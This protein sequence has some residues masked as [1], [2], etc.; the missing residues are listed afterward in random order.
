MLKNKEYIRFSLQF[1]LVSAKLV[2]DHIIFLE[3][4]T[5]DHALL[6]QEEK[7]RYTNILHLLLDLANGKVES[8]FIE[9][10]DLV[11]KYT[12]DLEEKTRRLFKVEIDKEITKKSLELKSGDFSSTNELILIVNNINKT[13]IRLFNSS[14]DNLKN[15][16]NYILEKEYELYCDIKYI[17]HFIKETKLF[18]YNMETIEMHYDATPTYAYNTEYYFNE[19]M[20][21]HCQFIDDNVNQI[22]LDLVK[23]SY[24]FLNEFEDNLL[25]FNNN[26]NPYTIESLNLKTTLIVNHFK[27]LEEEMMDS[28]FKKKSYEIFIPLCYDHLLRESNAVLR[29]LR[30][31]K[32]ISRT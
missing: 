21:E 14:I 3:I 15:L 27:Y 25:E 29:N 7:K 12:Q 18:I 32:A 9:A 1:G 26:I 13:L 17:K 4:L 2:L 19:T 10:H 8:N 20:K 22:N 24:N 28:L 6:I 31:L 30:L 16:E 11:T 5:P 23:E